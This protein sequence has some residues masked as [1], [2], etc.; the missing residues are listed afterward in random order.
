MQNL[1]QTTL[2]LITFLVPV[3]M[4]PLIISL[5][6][7]FFVLTT[8]L[9]SFSGLENL[10]AFEIFKSGMNGCVDSWTTRSERKSSIH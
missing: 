5:H 3:F 7:H 6:E 8:A 1:F 2:K 9:V 10:Y 4:L